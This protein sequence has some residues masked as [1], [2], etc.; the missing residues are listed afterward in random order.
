MSSGVFAGAQSGSINIHQLLKSELES[1]SA[2]FNALNR[3]A[4]KPCLDSSKG[5]KWMDPILYRLYILLYPCFPGKDFLGVWIPRVAAAMRLRPNALSSKLSATNA[6]LLGIPLLGYYNPGFWT[7]LMPAMCDVPQ[8]N[9][10]SPAASLKTIPLP[11]SIR[12]CQCEDLEW[13]HICNQILQLWR[14]KNAQTIPKTFALWSDPTQNIQNTQ[15]P[16]D[17][18]HC[19]KK[20]DTQDFNRRSPEV[21]PLGANL[22]KVVS[23]IKPCWL[24]PGIF[25]DQAHRSCGI[26]ASPW[27]LSSLSASFAFQKNIKWYQPEYENHANLPEDARSP[28]F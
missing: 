25:G 9:V 2:P 4:V 19:N 27:S 13:Q 17:L 22:P 7:L 6:V 5:A 20:N 18:T 24:W 10:L 1:F 16:Q 26:E 8:E 14:F 3:P 21:G 28:R 23:A 15:R 11:E 12:P